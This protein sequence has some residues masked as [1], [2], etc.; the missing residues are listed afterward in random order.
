MLRWLQWFASGASRQRSRD[1]VL[2][3]GL[4]LAMDWGENWLAPIQSR[5]ARQHARLARHELDELNGVC[6]GAMRSARETS[7]IM[8][9]QRGTSV[10]AED[11]SAVFVRRYPWA[12]PENTARL[13]RQG[14]Y[15]AWKTG[16]P[17]GG[18]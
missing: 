13:F 14:M 2:N 17:V 6:Q 16:G 1:A 11:F 4:A 18:T 3:D 9:Q 12:N 5:L 7:H 10:L 15:Y 8:V